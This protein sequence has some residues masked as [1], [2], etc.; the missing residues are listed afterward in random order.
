MKRRIEV[1]DFGARGV[2]LALRLAGRTLE[3]R[4]IE[5]NERTGK[6]RLVRASLDLR[7]RVLGAVRRS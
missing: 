3:V 5:V 7:E 2:A 6:V 4:E 1:F